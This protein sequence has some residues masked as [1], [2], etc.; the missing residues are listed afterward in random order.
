MDRA[1]TPSE[2]ATATAN[3]P[4]RMESTHIGTLDS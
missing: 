3:G 4:L 1:V 2:V